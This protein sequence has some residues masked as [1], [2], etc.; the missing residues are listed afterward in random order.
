M[1]EPKKVKKSQR[2]RFRGRGLLTEGYFSQFKSIPIHPAHTY[3]R[4][5]LKETL[6][7][8]PINNTI[9][10]SGHFAVSATLPNMSM[11]KFRPWKVYGQGYH[12]LYGLGLFDVRMEDS[13][14]RG[15]VGFLSFNFPDQGK[16]D[17]QY[18]DLPIPDQY[19]GGIYDVRLDRIPLEKM[20]KPTGR[21][22]PLTNSIDPKDHPKYFDLQ[23]APVF[24]SS[25]LGG[26]DDYSISGATGIRVSP[27]ENEEGIASPVSLSVEG[28]HRREG[29]MEETN[30]HRLVLHFGKYNYSEANISIRNYPYIYYQRLWKNN[31]EE[32]GYPYLQFFQYRYTITVKQPE[33][34]VDVF[35]Y[36]QDRYIAQD[37]NDDRFSF[38]QQVKDLIIRKEPREDGFDNVNLHQLFDSHMRILYDDYILYETAN[39]HDEYRSRFEFLSLSI[40]PSWRNI[41]GSVIT[42]PSDVPRDSLVPRHFSQESWFTFD[43]GQNVFDWIKSKIDTVNWTDADAVRQFKEDYDTGTFYIEYRIENQEATSIIKSMNVEEDWTTV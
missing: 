10:V 30:G 38:N 39:N 5:L 9:E 26:A 24:V 25:S 11:K 1:L 20:V 22:K 16:Q 17:K 2:P 29:V 34:E 41:T 33:D 21:L 3:S 42:L 35:T 14:T 43:N 4:L 7:P 27:Y 23:R 32:T 28:D 18:I 36:I 31:S 13:I 6:I 37:D 12:S 8:N 15:E 40:K 19:V